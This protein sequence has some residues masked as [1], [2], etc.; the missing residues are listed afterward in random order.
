MVSAVCE[1]QDTVVLQNVLICAERVMSVTTKF[2]PVMVAL[3]PMDDAMFVCAIV[4]TTGASKEIDLKLVPTT[5]AT[6]SE[7]LWAFACDGSGAH[8]T[9]VDVDQVVVVQS[10]FPRCA[11]CVASVKPKFMP[12]SVTML[13][14]VVGALGVW[15]SVSVGTSYEKIV[16]AQPTVCATVRV[17]ATCL[18]TPFGKVHV[19]DVDV[20]HVCVKHKVTPTDAVGVKSR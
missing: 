17:T 15:L 10:E 12:L 11:V 14:P 20:V 19:S 5:L 8:L 18:P 2:M 4:V 13:P 9:L 1:L 7:L 6:Y 16:A 3:R